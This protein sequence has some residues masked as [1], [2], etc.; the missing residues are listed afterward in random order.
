M[1]ERVPLQQ[2]LLNIIINAADAMA[3][4]AHATPARK[5]AR[6]SSQRIRAGL[7]YGQRVRIDPAS[8]AP[9]FRRVF[10]DQGARNGNGLYI[11]KTIVEAQGGRM[12]SRAAIRAEPRSRSSCPRNQQATPD[13][14]ARPQSPSLTTTL[15]CAAPWARWYA[16]SGYPVRTFTSAETFLES[17]AARESACLISD[18]RMPGMTGVEL[19]GHLIAAG[20][21]LPLIFMAAIP[22]PAVMSAAFT[23]GAIAFHTKPFDGEKLAESIKRALSQKAA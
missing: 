15:P 10:H 22:D 6:A 14:N 2:V 5:S 9:G 20:I 3:C 7:H 8:R 18:V 13:D 19:Q 17:S 16:R 11:C 1:G 12:W 23:A 21:A 4:L